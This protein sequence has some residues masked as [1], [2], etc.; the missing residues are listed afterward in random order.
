MESTTIMVGP[1]ACPRSGQ[2]QRIK[3]VAP[4]FYGLDVIEKHF[5]VRL[6]IDDIYPRGIHYQEG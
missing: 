1:G 3:V 4:A 2:G 6:A 5:V